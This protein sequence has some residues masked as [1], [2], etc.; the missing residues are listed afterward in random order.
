MK[1]H[2]DEMDKVLIGYAVFLSGVCVWVGVS[3]ILIH[4]GIYPY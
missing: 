3:M 2:H 4:N 1:I